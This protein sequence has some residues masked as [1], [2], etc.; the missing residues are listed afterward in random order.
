MVIFT[1]GVW[2]SWMCFLFP[3]L[4]WN[5]N[6]QIGTLLYAVATCWLYLFLHPLRSESFCRVMSLLQWTQTL[7]LNSE[8]CLFPVPLGFCCSVFVLFFTLYLGPF[9]FLSTLP[10]K[11][12]LSCLIIA[13]SKAKNQ[14]SRFVQLHSCFVV[15][16]II[17][18]DL[19][20]KNMRDDCS[21]SVWIC[22]TPFLLGQLEQNWKCK[23][24]FMC[25]SCSIMSLIAL[26]N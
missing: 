23:R 2:F 12:M 9:L 20:K 5:C 14:S 16:L 21:T 26:K 6:Q 10:L 8:S 3:S 25:D 11:R 22:F 1:F 15:V 17:K 19:I 18:K 13:Y 7:M 24:Y 4:T